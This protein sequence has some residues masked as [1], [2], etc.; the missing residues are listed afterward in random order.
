MLMITLCAS[1]CNSFSPLLT[2]RD[3]QNHLNISLDVCAC[4][5]E[6][7]QQSYIA[8]YSALVARNE[9]VPD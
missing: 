7:F 3:D 1:L 4:I 9:P 6:T 8:Q 2:S 5:L